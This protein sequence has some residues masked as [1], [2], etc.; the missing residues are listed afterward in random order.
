MKQKFK[1]LLQFFL[2]VQRFETIKPIINYHIFKRIAHLR[3]CK[4][5]FQLTQKKKRSDI[6]H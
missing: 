5:F 6:T 4:Q 1:I 3:V 2:L